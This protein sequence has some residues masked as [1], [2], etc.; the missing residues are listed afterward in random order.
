MLTST[1]I[2]FD[3]PQNS[4]QLIEI[5][6]IVNIGASSG[7]FDTISWA[8][9][10]SIF[11][12]DNINIFVVQTSQT[13]DIGSHNHGRRVGFNLRS[14]RDPT[15]SIKRQRFALVKKTTY[16]E[17]PKIRFLQQTIHRKFCLPMKN[18]FNLF[19]LSV[20]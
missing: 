10:I 4:G 15:A 18:L 19:P 1:D 7:L 16:V 3:I 9:A 5:I 13:C 2:L 11:N 12:S 6:Q 20:S 14:I 17:G 8:E